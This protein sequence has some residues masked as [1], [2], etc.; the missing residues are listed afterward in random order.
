MSRR[1]LVFALSRTFAL[2]LYGWGLAEACYLPERLF[3]LAH[4]MNERSTFA[5]H[6]YESSYYLVATASLVARTLAL[7]YAA[8]WFWRCGP[9]VQALFDMP[10]GANDEQ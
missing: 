7:L 1:E 9:R 8:G 4:F 10:Q 3:S 2:L 5:N 6:D